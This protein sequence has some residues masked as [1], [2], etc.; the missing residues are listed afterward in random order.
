MRSAD[1]PCLRWA[2]VVPVK[3]LTVAKTR[4]ATLAGAA[5]G[6]LALAFAADTVQAAL[7]CPLVAGVVVVT[8]EPPAAERLGALGAVVVADEPR[9]G[10]NPALQHGARHAARVFAPACVGALSADLPALRPG[11]LTAALT[12]GAAWASSFV[13]DAD[14]SGTTL[15]LA[16]AGG[17]LKPAF[18]NDS[19]AAHL[20]I[21]AR[22][23]LLDGLASLRRDVDTPADLAEAVQLGVGPHTVLMLSRLR[24]A[25]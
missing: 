9:A 24:P 25:S 17:T 8:D 4:L 1:Q 23:L 21:G 6:E 12:A 14:G 18:G 2:L 22:E 13:A 5:R 7:N 3:R 19:R 11:E 16:R 10:L 15:L 20:R